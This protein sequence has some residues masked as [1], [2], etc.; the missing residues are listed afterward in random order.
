M[1][2][3]VYKELSA[4]NWHGTL[5]YG[6][7]WCQYLEQMQIWMP[8]T[9][10]RTQAGGLG[11][12]TASKQGDT[13]NW[14]C[15]SQKQVGQKARILCLWHSIWSRSGV[16][17]CV[18]MP[19]RIRLVETVRT[20]SSIRARVVRE[21]TSKTMRGAGYFEDRGSSRDLGLS[22]WQCTCLCV[23]KYIS[24]RWAQR[25]W[26]WLG[27]CACMNV[28]VCKTLPEMGERLWL[29]G[30]ASSS[31]AGIWYPQSYW[32]KWVFEPRCWRGPHCVYVDM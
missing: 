27:P 8:V 19:D 22:V 13:S 23:R 21:S 14:Q 6:D 24:K 31:M 20:W 7:P 9:G 4:S 17:M 18:R 5:G 16:W 32:A 25:A 28:Y 11:C 26:S 29:Q 1:S 2:A 12:L 30:L 10:P 3:C 15:A